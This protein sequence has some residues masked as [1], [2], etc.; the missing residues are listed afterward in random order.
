LRADRRHRQSGP[1]PGGPSALIRQAKLAAPSQGA[2][3]SRRDVGYPQPACCR[4]PLVSSLSQ[5]I[6]SGRIRAEERCAQLA[7]IRLRH[8]CVTSQNLALII[9]IHPQMWRSTFLRFRN[10]RLNAQTARV[11]PSE[12]SNPYTEPDEEK[13]F[14]APPETDRICIPSASQPPPRLVPAYSINL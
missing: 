7:E 4:W 2:A 5:Q 6:L 9:G 13:G 14:V 8:L 11:N 3:R 1:N 12:F 10:F